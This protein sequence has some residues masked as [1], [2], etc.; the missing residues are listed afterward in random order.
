VAF[1]G[2]S[3]SGKST[4]VSLLERFYDVNEGEILIDGKKI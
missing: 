2:Q 4:I 1:V 3:G